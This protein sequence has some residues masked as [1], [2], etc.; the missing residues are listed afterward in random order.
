VSRRPSGLPERRARHP[1]LSW[2][3][4][5]TIFG[6]AA[7]AAEPLMFD[8]AQ[9]E[10]AYDQRNGEPV[11]NFRF[12]P[13]SARKFAEFTQRNVGHPAE[14]RVDGKVL[15]RPVIREPILGGSGQISS[16]FSVQEA[17]DL[18]AHLS[19]GTKLEVE[20]VAN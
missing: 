9:A 18:A 14:M 8:I 13:D 15:S 5:A 16:H 1:V 20:A 11:V 19:S 6:I 10:V 17:E 4:A 7:A 12:T 2:V 3:L